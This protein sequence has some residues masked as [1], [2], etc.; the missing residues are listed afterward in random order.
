MTGSALASG[1]LAILCWAAVAAVPAYSADRQQRFVIQHVTDAS[2]GKSWWS[3]LND[4]A[5]IPRAAGGLWKRGELPFSDRLRW[6]SRAPADPA[7]KAPDV[8]FVSQTTAGAE[9]TIVLRLVANGNEHVDLIAPPD[10]R[11]R[12]AG[13]AGFVRPV[14]QSEEGKY[15]I[16]CFGRSCDGAVIQLTIGKL[17]P[18]GFV[19]LGGRGTLPQ[20]AAQLLAARPRFA[21]PQYNRDESIAFVTR[22]L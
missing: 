2:H 7:A 8:Q 18:V 10:T 21:R 4:S 9:R 12:S 11:I 15:S 5:P 17:H 6:L 13:A 1:A 16:D 22:R 3:V 19:V 20:S 14:D